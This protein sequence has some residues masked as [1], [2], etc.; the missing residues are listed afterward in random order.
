MRDYLA[1]LKNGFCGLFRFSGRDGSV[2]FWSYAAT[3]I[4]LGMVLMIAGMIPAISESMTKMQ[5]FAMQNPDQVT[6]QHGPG[7]YSISVEGNHPELMPDIRGMAAFAFAVIGAMLILLAAAV[8]RRLH[9]TGLRGFWGLIPIPFLFIGFS[10]MPGLFENFGSEGELETGK[11]FLIFFN[12][13]LYLASLGLL[14]FLLLRKSVA[15]P[16]NEEADN[17]NDGRQ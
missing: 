13:I 14:F 4:F 3:I 11:F 9:D 16:E 2:L 8:C 5:E 10:L 1:A 7:R 15:D 6:I 17:V 12:N